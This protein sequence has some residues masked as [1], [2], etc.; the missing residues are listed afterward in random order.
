MDIKKI[1]GLELGADDYIVKPF[2]IK[3]LEVKVKKLIEN[4]QRTF[5]YFSRNSFMPKDSLINSSR[6]KEFLE[7]INASIEQNMSKST[8]HHLV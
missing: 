4:K 6:D 5:D 2:S 3:Y 7:K 8:I 1:E